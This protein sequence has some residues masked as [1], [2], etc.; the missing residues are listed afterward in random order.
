MN[1]NKTYVGGNI[2]IFGRGA[3]RAL[4]IGIPE[5]ADSIILYPVEEEEEVL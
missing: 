1:P 2:C 5:D 3:M 4:K